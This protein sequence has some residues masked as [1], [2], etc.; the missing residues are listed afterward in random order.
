MSR[1]KASG[2]CISTERWCRRP[3]L[4]YAPVSGKL[5]VGANANCQNATPQG[6][7]D[8]LA[9]WSRP[10]SSGEIALLYNNGAG[11]AYPY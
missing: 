3:I 9:I 11:R 4:G 2:R 5:G 10:L 8:E 6:V 7:F 1:F